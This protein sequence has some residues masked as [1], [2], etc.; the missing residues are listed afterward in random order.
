M[1]FVLVY[2]TQ[3]AELLERK[4]FPD[5]ERTSAQNAFNSFLTAQARAE[6]G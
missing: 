2:D 5:K 3:K 1:I 4:E 6:A